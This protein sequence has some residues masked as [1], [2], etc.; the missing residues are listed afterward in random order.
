MDSPVNEGPQEAMAVS[1]GRVLRL[2]LLQEVMR[3]E[4][5]RESEQTRNKKGDVFNS[6]QNQKRE[7]E[8]Q[9]KDQQ[10]K[11]NVFRGSVHDPKEFVLVCFF[12]YY[13][14]FLI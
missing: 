9:S 6:F 13:Y 1:G 11:K 8:T 10:K 5:G 7:R 12:F 14:Y 4:R 3:E 2:G